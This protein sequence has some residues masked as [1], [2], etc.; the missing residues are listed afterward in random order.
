MD[1]VIACRSPEKGRAAVDKIREA[2]PASII[3]SMVVDLADMKSIRDFSSA[4]LDSG[5]R[6]DIL[7][8]NAGVMACP[9][10]TTKDGFELQLG[11][12][13]LGHF[14]LTN[15]LLPLLQDPNRPSRI[16]NLSSSAHTF[17][18]I[19]FADIMSRRSYQPWAAYGQ[20]KLA[21]VLFTYELARRLPKT[22]SCTANA[23]HPGVVD[24]ELA[25]YLVPDDPPFWQKPFLGLLR[26]FTKRPEE[27][28]QTSIYLAS[29]P[30]VEGITARY[31]VD[32]EMKPS[33]AESYD[34]EVARKLWEVSEELTAAR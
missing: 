3:D 28:A 19:N 5:R 10:L 26:G 25:R 1:V 17:G 33:S 15:Q 22:A 21:N 30:G 31:W 4:Y 2:N 27:G 16:I 29:E 18:T 20:S 34:R 8:N 32:C 24:T 11:V 13:H 12:N 7:I 6:L 23:L 9:Q 14:A